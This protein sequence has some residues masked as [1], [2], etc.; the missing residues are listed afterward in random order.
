V[1]ARIIEVCA[2]NRFLVFVCTTFAALAAFWSIRETPL[3]AIPDLSDPQVIVYAEWMG[4]SPTLVED[5]VT[6]PLVSALVATPK[7][8]SV[9]GQSMFG[10]SFVYVIFEE[11]T[12]L[13]W[14]RSRV[15]EL[16][17]TTQRR[18][19]EGVTPTLGPDATSVG[20][21]FQYALVDKT[22]AHDLAQLRTYQDFTLR[23]AIAS[24]PGV[25]EV[26]SVGGFEQQYQVTVDPERMRGYGLSLP[27]IT[28]AIRRT[29]GD[30]GGRVIEIGGREHFVRGRGY[31]RDLGSLS[32]TVVGMRTAAG[33]TTLPIALSE[34][35]RVSFGPEIRRGVGELDGEG[36]AVGA[37]VVVRFGENVRTV[38]QRVKDKIESIRPSLPAGVE[39]RVVYDRT[40]LID[41]AIDTLATTLSEEGLVVA[42][43]I[44]LFLLH[45]RSAL[46]PIL[47]L[48]LG[49]AMAFIPMRAIGLT[50][51]IMSLGGIA[52]AIGAMVDAAIVIVENAHKHLE[53]LQPGQDRQ[54]VLIEA[55]KEVGPA[56]FFSLLIITV[57]FLP[58][59]T[60]EG[61]AGRLFKP[62]AYTKTFAMLFAAILSITIVPPLLNVLVRGPIFSERRHP[63]SRL[64]I[65]IY[66][67]FVFV[68]LRRPKTTVLMG[69]LAVLS[70]VPLTFEIGSEFMPPL[71]EGDLLYMP[72]TMPNLSIEEAKRSLQLQDRILRTFP[73]VETVFGKAGRMET[74]TDPAPLSMVETVVKLKPRERW[75][76]K[77]EARWWS[78]WAPDWLADT[79]RRVWPDERP[80]TWDELSA[81]MNRLLHI[82]GWTNSLTMPIKTRID[83]LATGVR[84]PIGVKVLGADLEAI[85]NV[86]VALER[87]LARVAGT[88]SV[89]YERMTGGAYI[90]VVPDR[91][92]LLRHGL[93]V[94]DVSDVVEA[95]IGGQP[96]AF[97]IDG[98]ARFAIH[99]RYPRALRQSVERI[100]DIRVRV[101]TAGAA[102]IPA[103]DMG[104]G[105]MGKQ[106]TLLW[107]D[108]LVGPR[109][110]QAMG[111]M[112]AGPAEPMPAVPGV[113]PPARFDVP[114]AMGAPAMGA[115]MDGASS[116]SA[117]GAS[118][119]ATN[120]PATDLPN[121]SPTRGQAYVPLGLLARVHI[122]TGP[123]ML[124]N[125][126]AMLAGYV[127]VDVD[128][129]ARD[130]G[131]YVADAKRAVDEA[132]R[133][134]ELRLTPSRT[135]GRV[136]A[137]VQ[138]QW[139]GQYELL[140]K[141]EAR[142]KVVLPAAFLLIVVLLYLQFRNAVE[143]AIVLLSIPFALVGSIWL[144]W[145][146][147]YRTSTAVWVGV[148]ALIGLAAQTGIVM[149]VYLD[150]AY[151]KRKAAG[152][153]RDLNDIIWAHMEGTVQRVRPK[154][155]TIL[156][157]MIGL[158]PL[159]WSTGAGA[160][161]MKRMAAP[162][163]GGLAT[164]AFLTLEIIPVIYTYWRLAQL[165]REAR[166]AQGGS[167]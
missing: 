36:E 128:T 118:G 143:V 31:L 155:M 47:L 48:P 151:E 127:Y 149:I 49:V 147:D 50:A 117:M 134:G 23:Y 101:P 85:E 80:W 146:L 142:L 76:R 136:S 1:I 57:S 14:A 62:L 19:P 157:T 87:V 64:L 132:I 119:A 33:G 18:L 8:V 109:L 59:F 111:E 68:A 104:A 27:Q 114:Q 116:G 98:R 94:G 29:S 158:V 150:R 67:P 124:R 5:Q 92:A 24:V 79:L 99:V 166:R 160:D 73:E 90:D 93:T 130:I 153:I 77:K 78:S 83:M 159:L 88:R 54:R 91:D 11:G 63:V 10:M 103:G 154:L 61:Q 39:V 102:P 45:L 165:K 41:R 66:K 107:G 131:G 12:D 2:H 4:R 6:H 75:R 123:S 43:V 26:A 20:W 113:A 163:I 32:R 86:G 144:L 167:R 51:N 106:G 145:A 100:R 28:S 115:P 55:A 56:I 30:S 15:L 140:E 105:S 164:S 37:V 35:A 162:M 122:A 38:V 72:T 69:A 58:V 152:K 84:T 138:L 42:I 9:R 89:F 53:H 126:N 96:I 139:T 112:R 52:I 25:A 82:P 125:E 97:T 120:T 71:N 16:L 7:V 156:V 3:D 46:L 135:E 74:A 34:V 13:Y 81:E 110:A 60:L 108:V 44:L 121:A 70:A 133:A 65:W 161:V 40:E 141:L 17:S 137:G 95:A 22:G 21:A 129:S 148:I